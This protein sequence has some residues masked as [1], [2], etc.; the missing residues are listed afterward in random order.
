MKDATDLLVAEMKYLRACAAAR[1]RNMPMPPSPGAKGS[2][3]F[4]A[5]H[6]VHI[7]S[8]SNDRNAPIRFSVSNVPSNA[9]IDLAAAE[10]RRIRARAA[11][12][13][14]VASPAKVTAATRRGAPG[15]SALLASGA[16]SPSFMAEIQCDLAAIRARSARFAS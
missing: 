15:K 9:E 14:T 8:A 4:A 2:S 1:A 16:I 12:P 10:V 13:Q 6:N 11:A 5:D 3:P 7:L